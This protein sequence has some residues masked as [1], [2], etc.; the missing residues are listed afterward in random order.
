M[1]ATFQLLTG[2]MSLTAADN[3]QVQ[4]GCD[5]GLREVTQYWVI[6]SKLAVLDWLRISF[7]FKVHS[8]F[9]T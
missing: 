1:L 7:L 5:N 6:L 9:V 8:S 4:C 2:A 3:V